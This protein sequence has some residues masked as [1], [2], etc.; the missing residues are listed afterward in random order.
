MADVKPSKKC[1]LEVSV[2]KLRSER[3]HGYTVCWQPKL[4]VYKDLPDGVGFEG[5][6]GS[7][8][9]AKASVL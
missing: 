4:M 1:L 7:Q 2:W 5:V 3:G 9:A 8:R 6:E